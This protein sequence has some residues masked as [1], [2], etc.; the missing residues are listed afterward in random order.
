MT[1]NDDWQDRTQ[2]KMI[3][4]IKQARLFAKTLVNFGLMHNN[5]NDDVTYKGKKLSFIWG[6]KDCKLYVERLRTAGILPEQ[7]KTKRTL[8]ID[9][10]RNLDADH[11]ARSFDEGL[12]ELI[13]NGPWG[14]LLIDH[15]LASYNSNGKEVT[16]YDIMC[17][18]EENPQYAPNVIKCVSA[19][20]VGRKRIEKVIENIYKRRD[21]KNIREQHGKSE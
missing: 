6:L 21:S 16:G 15:D 14:V 7:I 19:N 5:L 18:L 4:K 13:Q 11:I 20:P 8:L 3:Y 17:F 9:D 2:F 12:I 1:N 10:E